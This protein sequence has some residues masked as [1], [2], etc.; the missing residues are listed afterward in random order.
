M[1]V[2]IYFFEK[3]DYGLDELED[4]LDEEFPFHSFSLS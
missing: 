4:A 3:L 2:F 1:D